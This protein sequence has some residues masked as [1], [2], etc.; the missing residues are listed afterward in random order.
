MN[1]RPSEG[2]FPTWLLWVIG[3]VTVLAAA[4]IVLALVLGIQAG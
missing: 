3:P 2:L 4:L 1:E